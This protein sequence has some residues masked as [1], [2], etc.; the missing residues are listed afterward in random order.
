MLTRRY[1]RNIDT[2]NSDIDY[3]DS[4]YHR[5]QYSSANVIIYKTLIIL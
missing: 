1:C 5:N 3:N 2:K 4:D